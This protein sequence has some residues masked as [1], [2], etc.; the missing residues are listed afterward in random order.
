MGEK[1][2]TVDI[3]EGLHRQ[4]KIRCAELGMEMK[5]ALRQ[6]ITEFLEKPKKSKR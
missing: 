1:R 2:L 6:A 4:L 5:E 3:P